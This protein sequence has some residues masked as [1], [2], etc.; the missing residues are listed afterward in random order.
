MPR[1][2]Q[3]FVVIVPTSEP[4]PPPTGAAIQ[5]ALESSFPG[6]KFQIIGSSDLQPAYV[7]D[8]AG[9]LFEYDHM[10][11][12]PVMN[13]RAAPG[14]DRDVMVMNEPPAGDLVEAIAKR[15]EVLEAGNFAN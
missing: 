4:G 6:Y 13:S 1:E 11:V 2:V 15:L 10:T 8:G 5:A 12:M 14:D 9:A 3:E 7:A